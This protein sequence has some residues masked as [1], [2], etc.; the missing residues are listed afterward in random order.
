[1]VDRLFADSELA[2][3]YDDLCAGRRDFAFY[4]PLVMGASSVLD[5]GCGTGELLGLAR[6]AGHR[7]RLCG[8]DPAAAMVALA[9]RREDVEWIL[10]DLSTVAWD[11]AFELAVMTGHAFQVLL[12]DDD[13]LGA[14]RAVRRALKAGGRF[15]FETR[16]PLV[17]GWERWEAER[18]TE[19]VD[20]SGAVVGVSYKV[21]A[22]EGELVT[23]SATYRS[24]AWAQDAVSW[25]TLRFL[26]REPLV[27]LVER[28]GLKVVEQYGDWDGSPVGDGS[29]EIILVTTP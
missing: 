29:P 3:L 22:V 18:E 20:G 11:G 24:A 7:G 8:L 12:T 21:H 2:A 23:F 25:S 9:R 6:E 13:V 28:V 16:N 17:R 14:L 1:M 27:R 19:V 10:G 26:E 4:L 15:V 5:I